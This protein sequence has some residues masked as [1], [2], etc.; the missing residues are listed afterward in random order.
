MSEKLKRAAQNAI[1]CQDACNLS[2]VVFSFARD[3]QN[4]CDEIEGTRGRN[5]HPIVQLYIDKLFDLAFDHAGRNNTSD[6]A[7]A[8]KACRALVGDE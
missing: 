7:E 4:I 1:G 6:F 8:Y 2:G 3:M 5:Q